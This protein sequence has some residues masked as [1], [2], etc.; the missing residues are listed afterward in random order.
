MLRGA[1]ARPVGVAEPV[2]RR[3]IR[4]LQ[5]PPTA[6]RAQE[7]VLEQRILATAQPSQPSQFEFNRSI[8]DQSNNGSISM[9]QNG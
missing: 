7:A 2:E 9:I 3:A 4:V 6:V 5:K 8:V 1:E